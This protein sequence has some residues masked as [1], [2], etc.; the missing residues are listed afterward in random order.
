MKRTSLCCLGLAVLLASGVTAVFAE[1]VG[2]FEDH[3]DIFLT[4]DRLGADGGAEY[5]AASDT[6]TIWGSGWDVWDADDA[7]HFVYSQISGDFML[8]AVG[9]FIVEQTTNYDAQD[10]IKIMLMARQD[11]DPDSVNYTTRIRKD[12]QF[13]WQL[14]PEKG[15]N[16]SSTPGEERVVLGLN[17]DGEGLNLPEWNM[18]LERVG[19]ALTAQYMDETGAWVQ[20]GAVQEV[21]MDDPLYV[22]IGVCSHDAGQVCYTTIT[23]VKLTPIST[24][25]TDWEIFE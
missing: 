3:Q 19:N 12:G 13:S 14:R 11:L 4:Y 15:E 5:D 8:D 22:G 25:V 21:P 9:A 20:L 16:G 1:P 17:S 7:F 24:S 10:W 2:I 23:N 18:R 6:Y